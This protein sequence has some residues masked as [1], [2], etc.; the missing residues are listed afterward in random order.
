[1]WIGKEEVVKKEQSLLRCAKSEF[2][3]RK[4]FLKEE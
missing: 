3:N 2:I 1:M 4:I